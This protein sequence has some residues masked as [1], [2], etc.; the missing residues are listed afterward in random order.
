MKIK[1]DIIKWRNEVRELTQK[2]ANLEANAKNNLEE[3]KSLKEKVT[4]L[5][6]IT[7]EMTNAMLALLRQQIGD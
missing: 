3:L 5:A 1:E 7:E 2:V 4:N 6:K